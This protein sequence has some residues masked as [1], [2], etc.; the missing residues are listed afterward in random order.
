AMHDRLSTAVEFVV[1]ARSVPP[2]GRVGA[3]WTPVIEVSGVAFAEDN[4]EATRHLAPLEDCPFA[5]EALA[6]ESAVAGS[7]DEFYAMTD[8]NHNPPGFRYAADNMWS[9]AGPS[10]LIPA[11]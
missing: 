9:N 5:D 7:L 10:E 1:V 6:H 4:E 3:S 8:Q 2:D 11:L